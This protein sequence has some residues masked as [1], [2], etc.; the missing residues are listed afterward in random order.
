MTGALSGTDVLD[1]PCRM[2]H[3]LGTGNVVFIA[4]EDRS[5]KRKGMSLDECETIKRCQD[6]TLSTQ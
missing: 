6:R 3:S 2:K 1:E 4:S 5:F